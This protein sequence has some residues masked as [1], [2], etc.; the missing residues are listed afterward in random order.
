MPVILQLPAEVIECA[1]HLFSMATDE[2]VNAAMPLLL[3]A[4]EAVCPAA[5]ELFWS[6]EP[7]WQGVQDSSSAQLRASLLERLDL[8]QPLLDGASCRLDSWG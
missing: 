3:E 6:S 7:Q 8:V 1:A 4:A 2:E 5:L